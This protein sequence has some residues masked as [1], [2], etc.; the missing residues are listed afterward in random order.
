MK[1]YLLIAVAALYTAFA[2]F[3][4]TQA[5]PTWVDKEVVM[6]LGTSSNDFM[7]APAELDFQTG[8]SYKLVITNP[9]KV[10]HLLTM[11]EFGR[12]V[13][14]AK[15]DIHDGKVDR[16]G[17]RIYKIEVQPGGTAEWY[18]EPV[19]VGSYWVMC[20][21]ATHAKAGMTAKLVVR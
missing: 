16:S 1:R 5:A 13:L 21:I 7:I 11:P 14:T 19:K 6:Q 18:F 17:H 12:T 3:T 4:G 15:V 8:K 10:T 20:G 2:G 9:S